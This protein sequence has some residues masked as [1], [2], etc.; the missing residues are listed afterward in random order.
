[1]KRLA[2]AFPLI[3]SLLFAAAPAFAQDHPVK[4]HDV[5]A[6][7]PHPY[8]VNADAHADVKA[9]LAA[10]KKSGK[11]T[12][13]IFG[14]NWCPDC[15]S[16]DASLHSEKNAPLIDRNFQVVKI[17]VGD[18]DKNIDISDAYGKPIAKG[19]P[20]A[21]IVSPKGEVLYV[22]KLGELADARKMSDQGI[23]DFFRQRADEAKKGG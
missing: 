21:A 9:A 13:L 11:P 2:P 10:A 3:V 7:V 6:D 15:R 19:I 8:D 14:A 20:A 17:D 23:Y 4:H 16:L 18:W 5:P 12:L 1:M 22:T